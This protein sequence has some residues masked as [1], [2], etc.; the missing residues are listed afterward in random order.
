[1]CEFPTNWTI[2]QVSLI[3]KFNNF[4]FVTRTLMKYMT[5]SEDGILQEIKK[6]HIDDVVDDL[7]DDIITAWEPIRIKHSLTLVKQRIPTATKEFVNKLHWFFTSH[8]N[9]DVIITES[10]LHLMSASSTHK[11]EK[12][13][14]CNR[15]LQHLD[16]T[17]ANCTLKKFD[18]I[19]CGEKSYSN[20]RMIVH[21]CEQHEM[22][23]DEPKM[24]C[25]EC[26]GEFHM[27]EEYQSHIKIHG[28]Y[29][30]LLTKEKQSVMQS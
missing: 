1:M 23:I 10:L 29:Y 19:F 12:I 21:K 7:I 16:A 9:E 11:T 25:P 26:K 28:L 6:E 4:V 20:F 17:G 27:I 8:I 15:L 2:A 14:Q 18:C 30:L 22:N 24:I 13:S 5:A 3:D